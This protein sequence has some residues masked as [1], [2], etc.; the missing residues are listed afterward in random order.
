MKRTR[1][2][3][4]L[5]EDL[6]RDIDAV[7]GPRRR[8]AFL[9][10]TAREALKRRKLLNFLRNDDAT[11]RDA[12]HPELAQGAANWVRKLRRESDARRGAKRRSAKK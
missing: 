1:A 4:L 8:S 10:E 2:H 11:W 6:V 3:V 12:D 7:V 5:P 9:V